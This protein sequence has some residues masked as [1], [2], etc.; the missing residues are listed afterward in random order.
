MIFVI[1]VV[2]K[3]PRHPSSPERS[4]TRF[5]ELNLDIQV[6]SFEHL[7][8]EYC[9]FFFPTDLIWKRLKNRVSLVDLFTLNGEDR[10]GAM[11]RLIH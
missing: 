5:I 3:N 9:F 7:K 10:A 6:Q 11:G 8:P 4:N 2:P 1:N